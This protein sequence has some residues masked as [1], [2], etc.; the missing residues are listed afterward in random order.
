MKAIGVYTP[1]PIENPESLIEVDLP[2]P[3]PTGRDLQVRVK[4]I[5]VNPVDYKVQH[6]E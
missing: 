1:L 4:A 5:S 3:E 6:L 2:K